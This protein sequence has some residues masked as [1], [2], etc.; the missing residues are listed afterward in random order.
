MH[1]APRGVSLLLARLCM[2]ATRT[3][4]KSLR[5]E[6]MTPP[7]AQYTPPTQLNSTRTTPLSC[8]VESRRRRMVFIEFARTHDDCRRIWL[9]KLKTEHVE[10]S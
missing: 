2:D 10:L 3:G 7:E 9:K 6:I 4:I 5:S 8:Q 1:K